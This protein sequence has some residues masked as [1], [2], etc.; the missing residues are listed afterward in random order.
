MI[1]ATEPALKF[2]PRL[3]LA[4]ADAVFRNAVERH[5]QMLGWEVR[6]ADSGAEVRHLAAALNPA[7]VVLSTEGLDES[8]WLTCT[9]L[10]REN[11]SRTVVLVAP[12]LTA[13]EHAFAN[14]VGAA[15]IVRKADGI[16]A[17]VD[18]MHGTALSAAG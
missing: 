12:K 6:C 11:P 15:A 3:V 1:A 5:L 17:L 4:L 13:E 8:G 16:A 14:F 7:I 9:K 2:R 10:L 18:A